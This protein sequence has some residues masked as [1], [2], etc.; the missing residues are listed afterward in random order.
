MAMSYCESRRRKRAVL[1][2]LPIRATARE[3]AGVTCFTVF[4][5]IT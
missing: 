2:E 1:R 4:V 5:S 3:T